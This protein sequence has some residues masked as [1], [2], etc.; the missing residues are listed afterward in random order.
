[1]ATTRTAL[2][3]FLQGSVFVVC[4]KKSLATSLTAASI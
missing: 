1:M 2:A 4:E 3:E